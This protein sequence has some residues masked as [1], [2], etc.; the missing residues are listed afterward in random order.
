MQEYIGKISEILS[1]LDVV[2][3][4]ASWVVDKRNGKEYLDMYSS[5]EVNEKGLRQNITK[6][7][8]SLFSKIQWLEEE[9]PA[10]ATN[11]K[12]VDHSVE[13]DL[14]SRTERN[15]ALEKL[16]ANGLLVSFSYDKAIRFNP[17]Y[18]ATDEDIEQATE[19]THKSFN[20]CLK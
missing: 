17:P 6:R 1:N 15:E 18:Y 7:I 13:I 11:S 16:L 2:K 9:Y 14:P 3:S 19:I 10:Y 8:K 20:A 12:I 4:H 5:Y